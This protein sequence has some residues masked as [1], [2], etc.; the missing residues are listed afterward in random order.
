[1]NIKRIIAILLV[2]SS[3]SLSGVFNVEA[4]AKK[5]DYTEITL[6]LFGNLSSQDTISGIYKDNVFYVSL[7]T[8]EQIGVIEIVDKDTITT[9][10]GARTFQID[11]K[12]QYMFE[13]YAAGYKLALPICKYQKDTYISA[14]H[15]L[16]YIG[17]IVE[18]N[19]NH[20]LQFKMYLPYN[21]YDAIH[22]YS[23]NIDAAY[24][25]WYEID[26][27]KPELLDEMLGAS[28]IFGLFNKNSNFL[29]FF[30]DT[31]G[32]YQECVEDAFLSILQN[33]G[34][35]TVTEDSTSQ[36]VD[37]FEFTNRL[38][39][40]AQKGIEALS[41]FLNIY[42]ESSSEKALEVLANYMSKINESATKINDY[43]G[44][45]GRLVA[46]IA[47][48][49]LRGEQFANIS[50]SQKTLLKNTFISNFDIAISFLEDKDMVDVYGNAAKSVHAKA[51]NACANNISNAVNILQGI[52][53]EGIGFGVNNGIG[54]GVITNFDG[55]LPIPVVQIFNV[56]GDIVKDI[57]YSSDALDRQSQIFNAYNCYILEN[58][59]NQVLVSSCGKMA[60]GE[61]LYNNLK[62]QEKCLKLI[63]DCLTFQYKAAITAREN[64]IDTG[65]LLPKN[66]PIEK[67]RNSIL[68]NMLLKLHTCK[69]VLVGVDP[70]VD[71]DLTWMDGWDGENVPGFESPE[72]NIGTSTPVTSDERD[73]VLVLDNS[74]SMSGTPIRETKKASEKFIETILKEDASIGIV[75]YESDAEM[76]SNFSM[77]ENQLKG[78][79]DELY[80]SGGTDILSGLTLANTMLEQSNAKK[81]II[82][83]MS[84][85]LPSNSHSEL[86]DYA[87]ELRK[88]GIIIYTLGFF[89]DV[90]YDK[91]SA[92]TLMEGIAS[93][94]CHYEVSD[95]DSLVYFFGDV[96]DQISGQKYIYIRIACPV[97]VTVKYRGETLCSDIDDLSTRTSFGSL[98]FEENTENSNG[99]S[100]KDDRV[101]ILRLKEGTEYDIH[102]EGT[103]YG[104]MNY[105]IGFM[106]ENG[107]YSDLRKFYNVKIT[108]RTVIDTVAANNKTTLLEIDEDGD[109]KY[110]LRYKAKENGRGEIVKTS[111]V[112][113]I[114]GSVSLIAIIITS[115]VVIKKKKFFKKGL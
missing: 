65:Y 67:D 111:Y 92:Q 102:I 97:D 31:K 79:L 49:L 40:E 28:I 85:G 89:G 1:M 82:V 112:W 32:I 6:S 70:V 63:K 10:K 33:E 64:L 80:A 66:V 115:I 75:K 100:S 87:E 2:I 7:E 15:F 8:L 101:K 37:E 110:D 34:Q 51:S 43:I 35:N 91:L 77:D 84:D 44:G 22:E 60:N 11:I 20:E 88:K 19:P 21:I 73:I 16:R 113:I 72:I 71:E 74:G 41:F 54:A 55:L 114:V 38:M 13:D 45:A 106:D 95:A 108:N 69:I 29:R 25:H 94:G 109:G 52:L 14:L 4:Y 105:T 86:I 47:T 96:A 99:N 50:D 61:N 42:A 46:N 53:Y 9:N 107:E 5:S 56:V 26:H 58:M 78:A 76:I 24:F 27:E 30:Y 93:E 17:A 59:V 98:T 57:P 3:L 81:Q 39:D 68:A 18:I 12:K 48:N 103:G 90:G 23:E 104:R 62:E 36:M 83:L